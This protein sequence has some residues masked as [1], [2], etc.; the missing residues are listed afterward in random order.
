MGYYIFVDCEEKEKKHGN[1]FAKREHFTD[2]N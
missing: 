1:R 2:E